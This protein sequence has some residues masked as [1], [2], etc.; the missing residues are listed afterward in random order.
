MLHIYVDTEFD[1]IKQEGR[2]VQSII[3]I[4]AVMLD[5]ELVEIDRFY[6]LVRP[7]GFKRLTPVVKRMTK[8]S[9]KEILSAE[10]FSL[11]MKHF[12][13]WIEQHRRKEEGILLYGFGP[14]DQRTLLENARRSNVKTKL[15]ED[16]K[17]LQKTMSKQVLWNGEVLSATLSLDD[18]KLAYGQ[19]G[20]VDHNALSDALDLMHL[21]KAYLHKD[22]IHHE[23]VKQ[24]YL[25]KKEKQEASMQK[26][27]KRLIEQ[28]NKEF[29]QVFSSFVKVYMQD[30]VL[31]IVKEKH[32]FSLQI[33]EKG[34]LIDKVLYPYQESQFFLHIDMKKEEAQFIIEHNKKQKYV[35]EKLEITLLKNILCLCRT[36]M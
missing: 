8:L 3:S 1:A 2:Y 35:R 7:T 14:D 20:E 23:G 11:V 32:L 25:R 27:K 9:D 34:I 36:N 13:L 12:F 24:I 26:Q 17:D 22:E 18:M 15:F 5:S 4:G 19:K 21:H 16:M 29:P 10:S 33:K 31:D 28:I 6:E 30:D